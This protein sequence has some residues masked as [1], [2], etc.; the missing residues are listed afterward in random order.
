MSNKFELIK[1]TSK[2]RPSQVSLKK[3]APEGGVA[4]HQFL[5]TNLYASTS[6]GISCLFLCASS[7]QLSY[8]PSASEHQRTCRAK[9]NTFFLSTPFTFPPI[10]M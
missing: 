3:L 6:E 4:F 8:V 1:T 5:P 9:I 10:A 2:Q 7:M